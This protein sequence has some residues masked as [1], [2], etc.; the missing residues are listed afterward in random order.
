MPVS[1]KRLFSRIRENVSLVPLNNPEFND[2]QFTLFFTYFVAK[3]LNDILLT[4][5]I[6]DLMQLYLY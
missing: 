3:Y 1:A 2:S 6:T 5:A 4:F